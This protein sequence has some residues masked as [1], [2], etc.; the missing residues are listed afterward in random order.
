[1]RESGLEQRVSVLKNDYRDLQGQYDKLVS[2]E[3]VEAVGHQYLDTFFAQCGRLLKPRGAMLLQAITINDQRYKEA[4][5]EVD[6]IKRHI[7]PGGFLPLISVLSSSIA[8]ATDMKIFHLEDIG[9]HYARTLKHWRERFLKRLAEIRALGY[10]DSFV[11]MWEYY[12]CYC[13]GGF[14]ERDIGTVQVLLTKPN[15]RC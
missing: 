3:M 8:K 7:F 5:A 11:R 9:P 2:I 14:V 13:E 10:P 12:F 1:M 15:A 6:F 4:L